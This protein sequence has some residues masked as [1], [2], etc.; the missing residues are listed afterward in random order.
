METSGE[1][2]RIQ[3]RAS[4]MEQRRDYN[5]RRLKEE[6]A[7]EDRRVDGGGGEGV[8]W[9]NGQLNKRSGEGGRRDEGV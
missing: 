2:L 5:A 4:V 9:G 7:Q 3:G 6:R 1:A 8:P